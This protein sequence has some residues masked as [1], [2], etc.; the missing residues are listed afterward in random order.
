MRKD[1]V[2]RFGGGDDEGMIH[3]ILTGLPTFTE[4][5]EVH[6]GDQVLPYPEPAAAV[7]ESSSV[8]SLSKDAEDVLLAHDVSKSACNTSEPDLYIDAPLPSSTPGPLSDPLIATAAVCS[9]TGTSLPERPPPR[10]EEISS[11]PV[12]DDHQAP[13]PSQPGISISTDRSALASSGPADIPLP[14]SAAS[15]PPA[16]PTYAESSHYQTA[17]SLLNV[18]LLADD[19]FVRFPPSTPDL[20]LTRTLGPASAMRTWAQESPL[21]P[22]DDQAEALVV[23]GIDIVVRELEPASLTKEPRQSARKGSM[24]KSNRNET[25]LLVV[26]AVL[27]LGAAVAVGVSSHGGGGG[28]VDWCALLDTLGTVGER[29]LGRFSDVQL[30]L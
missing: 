11:L 4:Y 5:S 13:P 23:A 9:E 28:K 14:P 25:R 6:S 17:L 12:V 29:L 2:L 7:P 26:G 21:L 1:Q 3:S 30:G 19:L 24:K 16:S 27:V 10:D 15:T 18:L 22:S 8:T 20:C